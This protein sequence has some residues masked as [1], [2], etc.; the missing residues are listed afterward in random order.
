MKRAL[1]RRGGG[2]TIVEILVVVIII[3]VLAALIAPKFFGRV[4]A[5]KQSVAKQKLAVIEE[6]VDMFRYDYGR[7]PESLEELVTRPSDVP[8]EKWHLPAIKQKDLLDPWE[9]AFVYKCPGD[10]GAFDLYSLGADAQ[11]GGEGE[12]ADIVNW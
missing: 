12:N 11:A 2:F 4:G 1:S 10:H 9:R 5:A 6:A 8:E 3:G 7:F